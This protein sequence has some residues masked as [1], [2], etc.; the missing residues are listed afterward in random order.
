MNLTESFKV[1]RKNDADKMADFF[2]KNNNVANLIL[3]E[4]NCTETKE[5]VAQMTGSIFDLVSVMQSV[6]S[7]ESGT[8]I[9]MV[10][11][12]IR[13]HGKYNFPALYNLGMI[14]DNN[15]KMAYVRDNWDKLAVKNPRAFAAME[16]AYEEL[17]KRAKDYSMRGFYCELQCDFVTSWTNGKPS[18][19]HERICDFYS[20]KYDEERMIDSNPEL[21][22]WALI[23]LYEGYFITFSLLAYSYQTKAS[24]VLTL[25]YRYG[26]MY[27]MVNNFGG[28]SITCLLP[29]LG[30]EVHQIEGDRYLALC[31]PKEAREGTV[32]CMD[33]FHPVFEG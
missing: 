2:V 33:A 24:E 1:I 26:I 4:M 30:P 15:L 14:L 12:Y 22:K 8:Y 9:R 3:Q 16:R 25:G 28:H 5:S 11:K 13:T 20:H 27:E 19:R 10:A 31:C 6:R 32:K 18:Y 7:M 17:K 29:D 21:I 23:K